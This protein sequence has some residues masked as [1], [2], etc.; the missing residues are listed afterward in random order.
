[1]NRLKVT[2]EEADQLNLRSDEVKE[3]MGHVPNRIIRYGISIIAF[4]ISG[5]FIFSFFFR[6][7]DVINGIFYIQSANPPAFMLSASNGKLEAMLVA[8]K[9]T[10]KARQLLGMVENST[11][12]ESY[13]QLKN[14]VKL[15]GAVLTD[16]INLPLIDQL[17]TLQGA[18]SNLIRAHK[19]YNNFKQLNYHQRKIDLL[20]R[21]ELETFRQIKLQ[22][23]QLLSAQ[24][25]YQI[26]KQEFRRDSLLFYDKTIAA[27]EFQKSQKAL[28][29][30]K[31]SLTSTELSVSNSQLALSEIKSQV[32]ELQLNQSK[33]KDDLLLVNAQAFEQLKGELAEWEKRY[34]LISPM[35]GRV[36]LSD[37]W[38]ENQNVRIGQHVMT[39]IPDKPSQLLAKV[40]I[41]VSRAGK[42]KEQQ[43]VNLKF[44]DFPYREYGMVNAQLNAISE[45][46][47]SAYVGTVILKD[48]LVSNYGKLLPFKQNMQGMAEIITDDQSLAER[49]IYPLKAIMEEHVR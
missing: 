22:E 47:D 34:C 11:S 46:P 29:N 45:V 16:S 36:S 14:V 6:Y 24:Q 30:Q 3:I 9:D 35:D 15:E 37:I 41:P 49:M 42:V 5:I 44:T 40:I 28:V 12:I 26:S 33:E 31:M 13:R 38:E 27:A 18:Y 23:K 32:V 48:S 39:I 8:D 43:Q 20:K 10:V 2:Q 25:A 1:M 17:G 4:V 7:P 21:R 19:D